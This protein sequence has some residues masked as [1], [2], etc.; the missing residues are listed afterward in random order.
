VRK[1]LE[2]PETRLEYLT[3][4]L[5]AQVV[6]ADGNCLMMPPTFHSPARWRETSTVPSSDIVSVRAVFCRP[7]RIG[8][9]VIAEPMW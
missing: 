8:I 2:I 5:P 7:Y 3:P 6:L 9:I 1:R 4:R